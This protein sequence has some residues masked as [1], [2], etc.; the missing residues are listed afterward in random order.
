MAAQ[1]LG[2]CGDPKH[3]FESIMK[4]VNETTQG[5]IFL[6]GLNAFQ[7]SHTDERLS[8]DDWIRFKN[9]K[10]REGDVATNFGYSQRIIDDAMDL[11]PH[12]RIVD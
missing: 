8:M 1:A 4:E 11:F 9:K 10:F 3:V 5:Y 12:R 2:L 7:Y 6:Q